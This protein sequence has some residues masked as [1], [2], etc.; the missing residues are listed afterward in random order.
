MP[1]FD[2]GDLA[3]VAKIMLES[4]RLLAGAGAEFAICPDNSA[5]LAWP[6]L[7]EATP[8]PWLHIVEVVGAEAALARYGRVGVLGTRFTMG[9]TLYADVLSPMGIETLVPDGDDLDTVDDIIFSELVNGVF[10]AASRAAYVDVIGRLAGRGCDAVAL[11]CTEIP[12]SSGRRLAAAGARLD[13]FAGDRCPPP[14][15]H[16]SAGSPGATCKDP[17]GDECERHVARPLPPT[18]QTREVPTLPAVF[19]G[20]GSPMNTL[21][22]NRYTDSWRA[23]GAA[24][25]PRPWA[26]LCISAHWYINATAVTAMARPRVIHDFFGFPDE[27]FGFDYPAAGSPELA[28]LG[29]GRSSP[30]R[31]SASTTTAGVSTTVPG[32]CSP[33]S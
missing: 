21:E 9:G 24:S 26:I 31:G 8:I 5:H 23:F 10:T 22:R 12:L 18:M 20:H 6:H 25:S 7:H 13:P 33:T 2:A 16:L 1:A 15:A 4:A 30:R 29:G 27:L 11:A 28:E 3:G 32:R 17:G 19:F 14:R